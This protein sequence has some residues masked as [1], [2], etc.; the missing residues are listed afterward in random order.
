MKA[1]KKWLMD[2]E[3]VFIVITWWIILFIVFTIMLG[4]NI[5]NISYNLKVTAETA[6]TYVEEFITSG[7]VEMPYNQNVISSSARP[8]SSAGK[9]YLQ[10]NKYYNYSE[11]SYEGT[12]SVDGDAKTIASVKINLEVIDEY[13]IFYNYSD[14]SAEIKHIN[15]RT[16]PVD[17]LSASINSTPSGELHILWNGE[18]TGVVYSEGMS[19]EF[20]KS[21]DKIAVNGKET[22]V[23]FYLNN[24]KA[25]IDDY[26]KEDHENKSKTIDFH[27]EVSYELGAQTFTTPHVD[28]QGLDDAEKEVIENSISYF[29]ELIEGSIGVSKS[30]FTLLIVSSIADLLLISFGVFGIIALKKSKD[31]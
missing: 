24:T 29:T 11:K 14:R 18:D 19:V 10:I 25:K 2:K 22:G 21:N 6:P 3:G 30:A 16:E 4:V 31:E 5:K 26:L 7:D 23:Y 20:S 9:Y 28:T 27:L 8:D 1:I 17:K 13:A 15:T 12:L